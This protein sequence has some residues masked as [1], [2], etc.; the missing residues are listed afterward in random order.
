[1]SFAGTFQ[2]ND[3]EEW[4]E[5]LWRFLHNEAGTGSTPIEDDSLIFPGL[6]A[7][8]PAW[9][10]ITTKVEEFA[11]QN[12]FSV[13]SLQEGTLALNPVRF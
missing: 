10:K 12:H 8:N 5:K 2:G 7:T 1:M 11:R 3:P 4:A 6:S 9:S 13:E